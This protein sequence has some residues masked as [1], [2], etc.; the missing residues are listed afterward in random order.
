MVNCDDE[1]VLCN[2]WS[3]SAGSMWLFEMLPKPAPVEI[4]TKR[5]NTTTVTSE[6]IFDAYKAADKK[7]AGWRLYPADGYFHPIDGKL[8]QWGVAEPIA[9][10]LWGLGAIPSWAMM[11]VV[12]FASRS[13]M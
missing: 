2:L 4:Q 11:L 1:P 12:S 5:L 6:V 3:S 10:V 7:E 9:Y 13:M 8:A